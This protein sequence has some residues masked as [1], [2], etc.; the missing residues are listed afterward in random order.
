MTYQARIN[1][2]NKLNLSI[3][4]LTNNNIIDLIKPEKVT[5]F[6]K[7]GVNK[8]VTID[9]IKIFIKVLPIA[10]LFCSNQFD[11][12][13]LYNIPAFYNYGVASAGSNPWRELLTHIKTTSWVIN[14]KCENFPLLYNYRIVEENNN[15]DFETGLHTKLMNIWN[16]NKNIKK[17]LLD[18]SNSTHKIVLFLEYIPY[19]AWQ[20]L[21]K[22]SDF[23]KKFYDQAKQII[24]F[25]NTNN[26]YH[27]DAHLGN[28]LV[29]KDENL[30]ITDF[31]LSLDK[32]FELNKDEFNFIKYNKTL[33]AYYVVTCLFDSYFNK[34]YYDNTINKKYKLNEIGNKI[35]LKQFMF[36][37]IDDISQS[38]NISEF[39]KKMIIK[40]EKYIMKFILWKAA[41]VGSK[42]KTLF[43]S[44]KTNQFNDLTKI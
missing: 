19:V 2:Y 17:Y 27:N 6:K 8:I 12:T 38:A 11:T 29:D 39:H 22:H 23:A 21:N 32:S 13:N 1:N 43:I 3:S 20:Y 31:G 41:F 33:D 9:K 36:D 16:N 30:Y 4:S 35:D 25:L 24:K 15:D 37:N 10:K 40:Y 18:R 42:N 28:Y 14:G 34:C 5:E 7:W 44:K 26:V